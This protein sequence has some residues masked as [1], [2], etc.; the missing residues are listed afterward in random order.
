MGS[1]GGDL[2]PAPLSIKS[3]GGSRDPGRGH[4]TAIS[5][6]WSSSRCAFHPRKKRIGRNCGGEARRDSASVGIRIHMRC[7]LR[8]WSLPVAAVFPSFR[9]NPPSDGIHHRNRVLNR[10]ADRRG[11][12]CVLQADHPGPSSPWNLYWGVSTVTHP[13]YYHHNQPNGSL[14]LV[15]TKKRTKPAST[16]TTFSD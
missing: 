7:V 16:E 15:F 10:P 11:L 6:P 3:P 9:K 4:P 13:L 1:R 8:T 14:R 5:P 12:H 2:R